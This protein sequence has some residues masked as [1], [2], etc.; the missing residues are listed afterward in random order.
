MSTD[1]LRNML[2]D[3]K[4][5][6]TGPPA[7]RQTPS[8]VG[9][10]KRGLLLA[11]LIAAGAAIVASIS[12]APPGPGSTTRLKHTVT[13]GDLHVTVTELGTLESSDNT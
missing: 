3:P 5:P 11:G 2:G 7:R 1:A 4:P 8:G 9:W 12:D 6:P 10:V 13:R